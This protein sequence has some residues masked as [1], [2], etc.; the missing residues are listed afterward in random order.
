[1][2]ETADKVSLLIGGLAHQE[3]DSY[4][5]DSDL[6]APADDWSMMVS[7][8]NERPTIPD[9][10]YEGAEARVMLGTDLILTGRVG[11][12]DNDQ[13]K[14]NHSIALYGRDLASNLLDCSAPI[15][16]MQQATLAQIIEKSV[17]PFGIKN[18][19]YQAKPAAPRRKVHTELGQSVWEWL[20]SACEAN[21]VWPWFSPDGRLVIGAPDYST[22]L[23][24][25][26]V[27][28]R[29][30]EGNNVLGMH[31]RQSQDESFSEITVLGQSTGGGDLGYHDIKGV[32]T[33]DTMPYY[34]P[35][36][37]IDGNCESNE[38][39]THR[40]AKLIADSRM[41]RDRVTVKVQGH[42][43][44]TSAGPGKPW[45]PGMRAYL[46]NDVQRIDGIYY[47]MK[48]TFIRSRMNGTTTELHFVPDGTWLLNIPFIKAKR[49]SSYG[50]KKGHYAG[51][52]G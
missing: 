13:D 37:V 39:A 8:S 24:A 51:S 43:V 1:M 34:R 46:F 48:R 44:L 29:S 25:H 47:L 14:Q 6:L 27:M 5:I 15:V 45:E 23:V 41:A 22:P 9:F 33:D 20:K 40:A 36:T 11:T 38:L 7:A 12:I 16:S 19:D 10:I 31:R 17:L 52:N 21:Q 49:R 3:W 28:R 35:K 30:G 18:I 4:R 2:S 42:R 26:L 32:A 50:K